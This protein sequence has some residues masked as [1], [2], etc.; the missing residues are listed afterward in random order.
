MEATLGICPCP[1]SKPRSACSY[2]KY[3]SRKPNILQSPSYD[4]AL[5]S[6][7]SP[8]KSDLVALSGN[9]PNPSQ[10]C[11]ISE[12]LLLKVCNAHSCPQSLGKS[13]HCL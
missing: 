8:R 9:S 12:L 2:G 1:K 6:L 7:L 13:L 4:S 3:L 5:A 11:P 10:S